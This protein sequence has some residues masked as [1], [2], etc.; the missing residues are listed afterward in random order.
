MISATLNE[1]KMQQEIKGIITAFLKL[2]KDIAKKRMT[3]AIRKAA[4]PFEPALRSNTPYNSGSLMRSIKTKSKLYDHGGWGA[5]SFVAGYTM[6]T[7]KK[8]RGHFIIQG[9]GHHAIIVE[10]GTKL[11]V[12][13][14]GGKCGAMPARRMAQRTVD[15]M[16]GQILNAMVSEL[17]AAL[18]KTTKELAK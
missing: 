6:G 9:S 10:R 12:R 3:S 14:N 2:P 16:K 8:K 18:E 4:K 13:T 17:T 7:L 1:A 5:I 11:R 15:S